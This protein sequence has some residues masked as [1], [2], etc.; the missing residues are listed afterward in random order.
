MEEAQRAQALSRELADPEKAVT[1]VHAAGGRHPRE[2]DGSE[3]GWRNT[4]TV[5]QPS[6]GFRRQGNGRQVSDGAVGRVHAPRQRG[7]VALP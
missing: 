3:L 2:L 5:G 4:L 1:T 7:G 6:G